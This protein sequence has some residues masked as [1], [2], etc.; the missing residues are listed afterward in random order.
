M[1]DY[2]YPTSFLKPLPGNPVEVRA[3]DL[4]G[5]KRNTKI[6]QLSLENLISIDIIHNYSL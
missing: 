6:I 5:R 1:M 2:P 4:K 3:Y